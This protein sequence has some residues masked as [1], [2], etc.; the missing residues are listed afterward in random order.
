MLACGIS[1]F[2][3]N[4]ISRPDPKRTRRNL[5]AIINFAKF[6]EER[7]ANYQS[8]IAETDALNEHKNALEDENEELALRLHTIRKARESDA[9]VVAAIDQEVAGLAE[10]INTLNHT[11]AELQ[12]EIRSLKD[13]ATET[14]DKIASEVF[15]VQTKQ[16]ECG[17]LRSQ[18]VQSPERIKR[19]IVEMGQVLDQ[20]KN[21]V[22]LGEK[23]NKELM[24]R[25][26]ALTTAETEVLRG[27]KLLEE[28][29]A[30][31]KRC[32]DAKQ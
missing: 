10:E 7:L 20:E 26:D 4:D 32:D 29:I 18:I 13:M 30:E 14:A 3:L 12:K 25:L 6:R 2:T 1:D 24:A 23:K 9:P 19:E 8:L 28:C 21:N 11:Q 15:S 22:V 17:K 31:L 27:K 5:S 16:S